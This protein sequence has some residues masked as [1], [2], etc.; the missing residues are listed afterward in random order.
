MAQRA[1]DIGFLKACTKSIGYPKLQDIPHSAHT[2]AT[3]LSH[4]TNNGIPITIPFRITIKERDKALGYFTQTSSTKEVYFPHIKPIDKLK[5]GYIT[6][7][8]ISTI[9]N[10]DKLWLSPPSVT[11]QRNCRPKII[12][13]FTWSGLNPSTA[14]SAPQEVMHSRKK[15]KHTIWRVLEANPALVPV[16]LKNLDVANAYMRLWVHME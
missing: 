13:S 4:A 6:I 11:T 8:P 7:Y 10:L 5:A 1:N 16:Y 3:M 12:Y 15:V 14:W 9:A 2:A